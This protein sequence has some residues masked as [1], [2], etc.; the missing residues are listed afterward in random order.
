MDQSEQEFLPK[1]HLFV[2]LTARIPEYGNPRLYSTFLDEGLNLIL[3][4][5]A[6]ASHRCTF[7]RSIF[8]RIRLLPYVQETSAW[9]AI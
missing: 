3:A 6:S 2:H 5:V 7:E 4:G 1:S 9:A 8:E